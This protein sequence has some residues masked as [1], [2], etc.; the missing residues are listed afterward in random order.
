MKYTIYYARKRNSNIHKTYEIEARDHQDAIRK[1][2]TKH[3]GKQLR[4]EKVVSKVE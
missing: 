1:F 4:V 3:K 2:L